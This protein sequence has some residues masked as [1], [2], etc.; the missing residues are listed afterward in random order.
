MRH[1]I[2]VFTVCQ[3]T[4]FGVS[5]LQRVKHA[6]L[7]ICFQ[8]IETAELKGLLKKTIGGVTDRMVERTFKCVDTDESG[9]IDFI[10]CLEV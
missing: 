2:L 9:S 6:C 3:S 7:Y 4:N 8:L 10:E 1:F 5:G